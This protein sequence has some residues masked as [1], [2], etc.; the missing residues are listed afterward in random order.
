MAGHRQSQVLKGGLAA[1]VTGLLLAF[2]GAALG[3]LRLILGSSA[4]VALALV[5]FAVAACWP[6][7]A[8]TNRV[9][10]ISLLLGTLLA[11]VCL[12]FLFWSTWG[13]GFS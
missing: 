7:A 4:C 2:L 6:G 5:L 10:A 9:R 1:L 12:V 3:A 11:G 13:Q 8:G